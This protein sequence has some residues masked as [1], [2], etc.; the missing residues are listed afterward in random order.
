MATKYHW[1][2]TVSHAG[3]NKYRVVK[4][5]TRH[6]LEEKVEALRAQ[7]DEQ[8]ERQLERKKKQA[9][10]VAKIQNDMEAVSF[11]EKQTQLADSLQVS[12]DHLLLSNL[13]PQGLLI[14][15][16]KDFSE[17]SEPCPKKPEL[18][19][20]PPE[21]QISDKKYHPNPSFFTKIF[22]AK[23]EEFTQN[24]IARF[25]MDHDTWEKLKKDIEELN[26]SD[27]QKYQDDLSSWESRKKEFE[28]KQ[29]EQNEK[30]DMF[31]EDFQQRKPEAVERYFALVLE[32]ITFPF[33]Y[34]ISSEI[35]YKSDSKLLVVDLFLPTINDLPN[36]KSVSYIKSKKEFKETFQSESY[37]KKKYDSVIYQIVLLTLNYIF[38]LSSDQQMIDTAVIN[39]KISTIDKATG[40]EIEPYVLSIHVSRTSF[41]NINLIGVDP[42]TWFKS[43]KGV[44]A[45]SLATTTPVAPMVNM[46]RDD[47]RFIE[48][49]NVA[50]T[51]DKNINLAAIDWQDFE[52]LI[53]ELFEKEFNTSGGEVKITQASR[54]GGVD[55]V[56]F[57]PD[58][59]RGG[60]IVIQAKRYTNVVGVSAVRDL[61]GTVLNEGATKGILVTTS[62]YGNDAYQFAQGKPITLM[63][64]ANLLYLLEKHGYSAK[65]DLKEAKHIL[66]NEK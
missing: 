59:I 44:S 24:N 27:E 32:K 51:L 21:P 37:M 2:Q 23:M 57:D 64:G 50:D 30:A 66:H 12:L 62:N 1:Q 41:E 13:H 33:D 42:K 34:S 54:D 63:N 53:R 16:F 22:K 29:S 56:A 39:G 36:R 45:A 28:Q 47:K 26:L 4:A 25:E 6:E 49:Y 5:A 18:E 20:L 31:F 55:A 35:E 58:P 40:Q 48:G 8:W 61:Y 60:K 7:W 38:T 3:L 11:A 9:D 10:R 19:E 52:N 46:S 15:E 17:F 43:A 65:I 14:D